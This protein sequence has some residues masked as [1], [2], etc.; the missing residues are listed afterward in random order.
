[1]ELLH[2][3]LFQDGY[4]YII[5]HNPHTGTHTHSAHITHCNLAKM[6]CQGGLKGGVTQGL[7]FEKACNIYDFYPYKERVL[8]FCILKSNTKVQNKC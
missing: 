5:Q 4:V 7:L 1:M 2:V 8:E 6:P 3:N